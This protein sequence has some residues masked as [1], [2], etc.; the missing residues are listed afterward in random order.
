MSGAD[1]NRSRLTF[2]SQGHSRID[3][4]LGKNGKRKEVEEGSSVCMSV[5]LRGM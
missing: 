2:N 3:G 5:C 1:T 4:G